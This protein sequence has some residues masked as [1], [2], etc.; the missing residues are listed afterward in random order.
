MTKKYRLFT[1]SSLFARARVVPLVVSLD[2]REPFRFPKQLLVKRFMLMALVLWLALS[3]QFSLAQEQPIRLNLQEA[4]D[5]A[6]AQN[7]Q[8]KQ[9]FSQLEIAEE[10]I[11]VVSAPARW[12]VN[13]SGGV[14]RVQPAQTPAV[15]VNLDGIEGEFQNNPNFAYNVLEAQININKMLFDGGQV[16]N[17][18]AAARL[19]SESAHLGAINTWRQF[20]HQIENAYI[21]V[22][23]TE[24]QVVN[25]Q[26]SL[27]LAQSN[28]ITAQKQF[29]AGQVPRGDVVFAQV[30][31]AQAQLEV[32]R[33]LFAGQ[34]A[35]EG[36]LLLLGLPQSTPL[37]VEKVTPPED[38]ALTQEVALERALAQRADLKSTLTE[39]E[40]AAKTLTAVSR[41]TRPRLGL[42][43]TVFPLGFD[44]SQLSRGGYRVGLVLQWP[45]LN[46]NIVDHET[47]IAAAQL[48]IKLAAIEQKRQQIE[49][50]VREAYRAFE[51]SQKAKESTEV[52]LTAASESLRI[53]QGQYKAG[54]ANFQVVNEQQREL[55]RSQGAYTESVYSYMLALAALEQSMGEGVENE[56]SFAVGAER[57]TA[58]PA[59]SESAPEQTERSEKDST[60]SSRQ[61]SE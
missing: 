47:K 31:V 18:I 34:S 20:Y 16:R 55:V 4:V 53:A 15:R 9:L 46:G 7:P 32:E 44:G 8:I 24:E 51:L 36:L 30:P 52:Q 48:E 45:I 26:T 2:W 3:S 5:I 25:A 6:L 42:A 33:S 12:V 21:A 23:R 28:L 40:A 1:S 11:Q 19:S 29:E 17:Q 60:P 49:R 61:E 27:E 58:P 22:L 37:E 50:E 59:S 43:G 54:L 57:P 41:G 13:A 56:E 35:R 39:A 14:A 10:R 38:V